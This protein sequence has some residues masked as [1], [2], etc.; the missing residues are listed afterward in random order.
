[1]TA[2]KNWIRIAASN[3]SGD[4]DTAGDATDDNNNGDKQGEVNLTMQ[5][6]TALAILIEISVCSGH[7]HWAYL[8]HQYPSSVEGFS[9]VFAS[10]QN[11]T[12]EWAEWDALQILEEEA[13]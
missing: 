12:Q 8:L 1:M 2:E 6:M 4:I 11:S 10:R 5:T 3:T 9:P 7:C 13:E